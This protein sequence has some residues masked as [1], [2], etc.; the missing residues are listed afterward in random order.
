M[1]V[2][3]PPGVPS[4]WI[5]WSRSGGLRR[6]TIRYPL[7]VQL[8]LPFA[9]PLVAPSTSESRSPSPQAEP[10]VEFVRMR[11]AN[12]YI[13][14]VRPDGSLRVTIPRGGSQRHAQ[15]FLEEQRRWAERERLRVLAQHAPAR[16]IEGNTI[17][18]RGRRV[19]LAVIREDGVPWLDV[20]GER[21]LLREVSDD[22]RPAAEACL[23]RIARRELIPRL[24]ELARIH[25]LS[26]TRVSIRNQ[27]SRWGSCARS[28]AVALNF[29]LVQTP[30]AVRDYVLIHELMHL[31]QQNHSKR[32]WRLV[33]AACPEYRGSEHWLRT[34][35]RALF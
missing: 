26:V 2:T 31:K 30:D 10:S 27:R 29:R 4:R 24:Q 9:S 17:L 20:D 19:R 14:R 13:I 32:F 21:L 22:L 35:G 5:R 25:E 7:L 18:L 33:E 1:R 3:S 23:T 15:V 11:R 12:R 8:A 28:G 6:R 16:W 34:E